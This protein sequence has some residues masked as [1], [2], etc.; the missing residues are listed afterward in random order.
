[1]KNQEQ[2]DPKITEN[3]KINIIKRLKINLK[4]LL[5]MTYYIILCIAVFLI[6]MF[7]LLEYTG[8][9][10]SIVTVVI[11]DYVIIDEINKKKSFYK[12]REKKQKELEFNEEFFD[13]YQNHIYIIQKAI[14]SIVVLLSYGI[15]IIC[16]SNDFVKCMFLILLFFGSML[17]Y[18]KAIKMYK[19]EIIN[20]YE[21]IK[22]MKKD[23]ILEKIE[24]EKIELEKY[25]DTSINK[26]IE[27]NIFLQELNKDQIDRIS[28]SLETSI[29]EG[30]R[31]L[32]EDKICDYNE[33]L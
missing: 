6:I 25:K 12:F 31:I 9:L 24:L 7:S 19:V 18:K 26:F 22:K 3:V 27:Y 14:V 16:E 5:E 21:E 33:S 4:E 1:M 20:V 8:V 15:A 10:L 28:R 11:W 30:K 32:N 17:F 29:W 2:I 13:L 23:E